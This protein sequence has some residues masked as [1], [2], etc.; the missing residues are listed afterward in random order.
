MK[1]PSSSRLL[2][3][4]VCRDVAE[5]LPRLRAVLED[6]A[7]EF[8]TTS[9]IICEGNSEDKT[10][11]TLKQ[12]KQ[13][14][15]FP[16]V[17]LTIQS[18]KKHRIERIIEARNTIVDHVVRNHDVEDFDYLL[19]LDL[20]DANLG[21]KGVT[22]CWEFSH[23]NWS[24][25]AK[26]T[27]NDQLADPFAVRTDNHP[28]NKCSPNCKTR[29][30][31]A[32]PWPSPLTHY[33]GKHK[34]SR[35]ASGLPIE[36]LSAFGSFAFYVFRMAYGLVYE[37]E[38]YPSTTSVSGVM[39]DLDCEHVKYHEKIRKRGGKVFINPKLSSLG[40]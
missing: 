29:N 6:I 13:D 36:V 1:P 2:I 21:L 30:G 18:Q 17:V 27:C 39:Y 33:V 19:N 25:V 10:P 37:S 35:M 28:D 20:D 14:L 9:M 38:R 32:P 26:G 31:G 34:R 40:Y 22:S 5:Y 8:D 11:E 7:K 24:V 3:T 23:R 15:P 16:L 12:L 4:G